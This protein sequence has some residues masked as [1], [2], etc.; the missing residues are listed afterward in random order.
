MPQQASPPRRLRPLLAYLPPRQ[1]RSTLHSIA[2]LPVYLYHP[3]TAGPHS[4]PEEQFPCDTSKIPSTALQESRYYCLA[5]ALLPVDSYFSI[6]LLLNAN[7]ALF[8]SSVL[9][10]S[11]RSFYFANLKAP[12]LNSA[13]LS[14]S[15]ASEGTF[16]STR[17]IDFSPPRGPRRHGFSA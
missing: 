16:E 7:L 6:F 9:P 4:S 8:E 2:A 13:P 17:H 14:P 11:D 1:R 5:S 15:E 3:P 12:A 10:R